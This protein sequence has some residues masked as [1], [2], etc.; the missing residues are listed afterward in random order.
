[1]GEIIDHSS[2]LLYSLGNISPPSNNTLY[3][4]YYIIL[5]LLHPFYSYTISTLPIEIHTGP[6]YFD[7]STYSSSAANAQ[8]L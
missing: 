2:F 6:I 1:M 3:L 5:F 7:S 8:S 4:L